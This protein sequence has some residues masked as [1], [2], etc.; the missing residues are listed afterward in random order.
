MTNLAYQSKTIFNIENYT[1]KI[2]DDA[3]QIEKK[4]YQI[5]HVNHLQNVVHNFIGI[6]DDFNL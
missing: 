6:Y 5:N 3:Y 2:Q 1:K 4:S